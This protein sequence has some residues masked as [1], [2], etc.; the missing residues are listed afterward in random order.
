MSKKKIF[1]KPNLQPPKWFWLDTDG[2]W[3]CNCNH[4]GCRNCKRLKEMRKIERDKRE[5]KEKQKI[6]SY[7]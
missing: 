2:C 1:R 4:H 7:Y 6:Q 5:R 3:D